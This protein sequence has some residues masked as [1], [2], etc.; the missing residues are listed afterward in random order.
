[1]TRVLTL[2]LAA[3]AGAVAGGALMLSI[4]A[5]AVEPPAGAGDR[6]AP[7]G[8]APLRSAATRPPAEPVVLVW[9]AGQLP[10]GLAD[11]VARLPRVSQVTVVAGGRADLV[12]SHTAAGE[13]VDRLDPGWAAP[14][15][16]L[17]ID[18]DSYAGFVPATDRATISQLEP[19][20]ALLGATSARLRRLDAGDTITLGTGDTATVVG[21]VD[22][23]LVGGAELVV[24]RTDA[25]RLGLATDRFLLVAH[26]SDRAE[27][28][29]AIRQL[30][31]DEVRVRG[32]GE[33][34]FLRHGDA[35]LPQAL[36]KERFG[37]FAY[38]PP[39]DGQV[40]F[41]QD[42]AWSQRHLVTARLPILGAVHCHRA[43]VEQLR[44]ALQELVDGGLAHLVDPA[45]FAGCYNPRLISPDGLPS[46]HAWAIAVDLNADRNPTGGASGQDPRL[47]DTFARW[48][49][50]WGGFWL[51]P[52]PM[53][54][55]YLTPPAPEA[56]KV[57]PASP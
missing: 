31:D 45:T 21:V 25:A 1:M 40:A 22:D 17:A 56:A 3:V 20:R 24:P 36:I 39:A 41:T 4:D 30:T 15:D 9:T 43:V 26:R 28:E 7:L 29:S 5:P 27:L 23:T 57:A 6:P 46:R 18:P 53:H 38:R 52:D 51:V 32:P 49:L 16:A 50:T 34:P 44:G 12:A 33:T 47:V 14:L 10:A 2:V 19:G 37:E 42:P 54:F 55:E 8:V 48:G 13:P 35:V 11:Q